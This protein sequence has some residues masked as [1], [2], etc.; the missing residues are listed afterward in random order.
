MGDRLT[1]S[2][3]ALGQA[4]NVETPARADLPAEPAF[5]YER[6]L[7]G[8]VDVDSP[9]GGSARA[10][11]G[12]HRVA[13][14]SNRIVVVSADPITVVATGDATGAEPLGPAPVKFPPCANR[15]PGK[16]DRNAHLS[17]GRC[18]GYEAQTNRSQ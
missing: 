3:T 14:Q 10:T 15:V 1:M 17:H 4:P 12:A 8:G 6:W 13:R 16:S 7:L 2:L 9:G 11:V 18:A 5:D